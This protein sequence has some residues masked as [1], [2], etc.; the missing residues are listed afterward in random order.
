[1]ATVGGSN[2]PNFRGKL[3]GVVY[4]LLN[5]VLIARTIGV[6]NNPPTI[7]QLESRVA[8]RVVEV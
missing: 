3:G 1:M 5:D 2:Q 6:N 8:T 7:P 4:Y